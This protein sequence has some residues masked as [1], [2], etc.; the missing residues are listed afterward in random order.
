MAIED[1]VDALNYRLFKKLYESKLTAQREIHNMP[2]QTK[3]Y[4]RVLISKY[5]NILYDLYKKPGTFDTYFE[6]YCRE[7][8]KIG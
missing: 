1:K 2:P 6:K 7:T 4:F 3:K 5:E 8:T